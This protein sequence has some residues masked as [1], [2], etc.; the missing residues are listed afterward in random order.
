MQHVHMVIAVGDLVGDLAGAVGAVVVDDEQVRVGHRLA[1]SF[2]DDLEVVAFVVRR[3]DDEHLAQRHRRTVATPSASAAIADS[4]SS[5]STPSRVAR[6]EPLRSA[7]RCTMTSREKT[8]VLST[9]RPSGAIT[10]LTPLVAATRTVRPCSTARSRP[11]AS[12]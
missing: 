5:G 1:Q 4:N 10:A 8:F 12:C 7:T 9:T 2:G 6:V 3:Y 11:I